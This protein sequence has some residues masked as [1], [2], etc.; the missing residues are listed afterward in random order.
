MTSP[1]KSPLTYFLLV[2]LLS[3]PFWIAG[4]VLGKLPV[5]ID[6]PV[7]ALMAIVPVSAALILVG[8]E[9]GVHGAIDF[10]RGALDI[11]KV[12]SLPWVATAILFAPASLALSY[13]APRLS[14]AGLPEPHIALAALPA[15]I[16]AFFLAGL[17]EELGWQGYIFGLLRSRWTALETALLLGVVW[18][19]WH[20]IPYFQTDHG[21][22]WIAW[23]CGVTVL[24]RVITVW[25]YVNAGRSVLVAAIFHGMCNVGF[26]LFPN[27]GSQYDPF[28][29][30]WVLLASVVA[31]VTV[32]GPSLTRKL[33]D[34]NSGEAE[35]G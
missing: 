13:L 16:P 18:A 10:L 12:R 30:F 11:R 24:L 14:K 3:I 7:S 32:T 27:Y 2:L 23:H 29:F 31:I 19:A 20:L 34:D 17:C 33:P 21:T 15:F 5:P 6:L 25:I 8:R 28:W 35:A 9:S 4:F 1:T 22:G 26:F